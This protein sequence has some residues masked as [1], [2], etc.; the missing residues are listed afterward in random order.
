TASNVG[1]TATDGSVVSVVDTLPSALTATAMSGTG[2]TCTLG[3]LT[4]T[5]SD[6]LAANSSYP[7]ITLTV[8]VAND[9]TTPVTNTATVA[10]RGELDTSND[11]AS[12]PTVIK[13]PALTINMFRG[14]PLSQ[15]QGFASYFLNVQNAGTAP[16]PGL[17]TVVD[18]L[19]SG[20]T[21]TN[22]NGGGWM[23]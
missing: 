20:L 16:S 2:W 13:E 10:G 22:I 4:C 19:P 11:G 1:S 23:C 15:G 12:D 9:A 17:V 18:A 3:T 8:D 7:D 21:A 14:T 6:M 5:R